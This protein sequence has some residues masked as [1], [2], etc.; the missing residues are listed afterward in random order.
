MSRPGGPRPQ[1]TWTLLIILFSQTTLPPRSPHFLL[2]SQS[3]PD[4]FPALCPSSTL[5]PSSQPLLT[6]I[7]ASSE[8]LSPTVPTLAYSCRQTDLRPRKESGGRGRLSHLSSRSSD[9]GPT[10]RSH[11]KLAPPQ[12]LSLPCPYPLPAAV[13]FLSLA[14][15]FPSLWDLAGSAG[16]CVGGNHEQNRQEDVPGGPARDAWRSKWG[17]CPR[18]CPLF[19]LCQRQAQSGAGARVL[20]PKRR[21]ELAPST[22][23]FSFSFCGSETRS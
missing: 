18:Q 2:P 12:R 15:F 4:P 9:G 19:A 3:Y 11:V 20:P 21:R 23:V 13:G 8:S 17:L 1:R 10:P 16:G 6:P 5:A 22:E 14:G 7:T